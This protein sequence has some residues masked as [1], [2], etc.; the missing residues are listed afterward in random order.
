MNFKDDVTEKGARN[1][2]TISQ[3][4]IHIVELLPGADEVEFAELDRMLAAQGITP[5]AIFYDREE[6][7]SDIT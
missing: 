5:N 4:G 3:I 1:T 7:L 6:H 2:R